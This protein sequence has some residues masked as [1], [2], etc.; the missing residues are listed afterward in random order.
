MSDG[1]S[2]GARRDARRTVASSNRAVLPEVAPPTAPVTPSDAESPTLP[3]IEPAPAVAAVPVPAL[4][5]VSAANPSRQIIATPVA[6]SVAAP[7]DAWAAFAET[8]AAFA[9]GF[10]EIATEVNGMARSGIAASTDAAVAL[11]AARSF[12]EA[13]EIN[14]GLARRG[15]DAIVNS[16]ARLSEIGVRT[17][18]EASRPILLRFGEAWSAVTLD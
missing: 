8:Q 9:R 4:P 18:M 1:K 11:L 14:A 17:A 5:A 7:D 16:S 6:P 2:K 3:P 12:A 15:V 13:V 10:E